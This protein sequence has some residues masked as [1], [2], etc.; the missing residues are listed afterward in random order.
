[1]I[2]ITESSF[3][4][5]FAFC[6]LRCFITRRRAFSS[7]TIRSRTRRLFISSLVSPGPR[8]PIPPVNLDM[9][10]FFAIRRGSRYFNCASS[11]WSLP[12]LVC[13]RWAKI[14]RIS[15]VLSITFISVRSVIERI[16][17]GFNSWSKI[18]RVAPFVSARI[19]SSS[20]FPRPIRNLESTFFRRCRIVSA[21]S[22]PPD[23]ARSVSSAIESLAVVCES[24]VTLTRRA[25][26][27]P[28][29]DLCKEIM[30]DSSA[31]SALIK[32]R[33]PMSSWPG[34]KASRIW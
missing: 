6:C 22:M 4:F 12:S 21:T 9:A 25:L 30:W 3:F 33:H 13:A 11:T 1:M 5:R 26:S 18:I 34:F 17:E 29:S 20:S 16:C 27:F 24:V 8:P 2:E 28:V 23:T 7:R 19:V 15:W 10:V 31:S 32:S 14:S